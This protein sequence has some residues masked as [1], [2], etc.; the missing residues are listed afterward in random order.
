MEVMGLEVDEE[1]G[2]AK[3]G[4]LAQPCDALQGKRCGIYAYRPECCRTFECRLLQEARR[5]AVSVAQAVKHI[6]EALTQ[7]GQVRGLAAQLGQRGGRLPLK[8][9]CLEALAMSDEATANPT[10]NRKRAQFEAE[11][12]TVEGLI[13]EKFLGD[14]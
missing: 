5:G 6:A 12:A 7:V 14:G 9:H 4:L 1:D 2:D 13:Q 8:E 10:L 11:M 3:G